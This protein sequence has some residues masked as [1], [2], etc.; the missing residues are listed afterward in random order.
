MRTESGALVMVR[1]ALRELGWSNREIEIDGLRAQA[2]LVCTAPGL[3]PQIMMAAD[4]AATTLFERRI[5]RVGYIASSE[6]LSGMMAVDEDLLL[7]DPVFEET[8]AQAPAFEDNELPIGFQFMLVRHALVETLKLDGDVL[9]PLAPDC[10]LT[11]TELADGNLYPWP[12][13]NHLIAHRFQRFVQRLPGLEKAVPGLR[14]DPGVI[15]AVTEE[16]AP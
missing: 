2:E 9:I 11:S 16:V 1:H 10:P 12:R 13:F 8:Y 4:L 15:A 6:S 3:L 14:P 5:F 7:S